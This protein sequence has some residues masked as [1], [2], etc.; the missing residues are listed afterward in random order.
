M[1][2]T[3]EPAGGTLAPAK[4][5]NLPMRT[6][7][8]LDAAL[9]VDGIKPSLRDMLAEIIRYVPQNLPFA[10]VFAHK[11]TL[12]MGMGVTERTV[13]RHIQQLEVS[14]LIEV[15][16]QERKSRNGRF[17]VSRIRLTRRSAI[18]V[19]LIEPDAAD[20]VMINPDD[21]MDPVEAAP[22]P[23][24][25]ESS[26][27]AESQVIHTP[28]SDNLSSGQS[29]SVPTISKN[30]PAGSTEN[31][32]PLDLTWLTGNGLSRPGIFKLMGMAKKHGKLLSD[33]V[34]AVRSRLA[35]IKGAKL[36]AYLAKLTT[37]PSDFA[38]D[39]AN[40]RRREKEAALAAQMSGKAAVF[41]ARFCNVALTNRD[42]TELYVIDR[43]AQHV[44]VTGA[45][46]GSAPLNDRE[47][48]SWMKLVET[49][50]VV[51]ASLATERRLRGY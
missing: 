48:R 17:A 35:E 27:A 22:S 2:K 11:A 40:E 9:H 1:N 43:E 20:L 29:L 39:A 3:H 26:K 24:N 45:R 5:K 50:A 14:G 32:L 16:D 51:L 19:G 33:I 18:L 13:Y 37:G 36:Y 30:Q 10:T 47:F 42:Q 8:A 49:G 46:T 23:T 21:A 6:L 7:R 4:R 38:V 34:T 41:K 12:A 44:Q 31:G 25:L 28:P 15:L